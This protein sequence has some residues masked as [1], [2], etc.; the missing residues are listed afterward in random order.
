MAEIDRWLRPMIGLKGSDLHLRAGS[1]PMWRVHGH[2]APIPD[3]P[4][5]D[6]AQLGK[7]MHEIAG[8]DRWQRYLATLDFDFAYAMGAEARFRVNFLG[9]LHGHGCVLRHI[10]AK[11]LTLADLGAPEVLKTLPHFR[12]GLV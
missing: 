5:L 7:L 12:N 4:V 2:L 10:P 11:V 1:P 3:E 9:Q 8:D 6:Q